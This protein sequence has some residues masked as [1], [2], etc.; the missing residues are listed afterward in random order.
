MVNA[1]AA[2]DSA[3]SDLVEVFEPGDVIVDGGNSLFTDTIARG[4]AVRQAG[5]FVGVGISG[6]EVG[7]LEGPSMM[8]GGTESAWSRLRPI[9]EPI[10]ARAA[11]GDAPCRVQ[12]RKRRT[13]GSRRN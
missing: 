10:A 6:G 8:V 9:L 13:G 5:A 7:A 1:G 11:T 3:I 4:E 2:T 12:R